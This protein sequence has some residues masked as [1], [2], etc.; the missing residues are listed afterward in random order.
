ML[1]LTIFIAF[2]GDTLYISSTNKGNILSYSFMKVYYLHNRPWKKGSVGENF[3]CCFEVD[4][5]KVRDMFGVNGENFFPM[6]M[7][8]LCLQPLLS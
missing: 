2:F 3:H 5:K 8:E 6:S 1:G 4:L 7:C